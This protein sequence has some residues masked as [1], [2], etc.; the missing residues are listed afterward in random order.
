MIDWMERGERFTFPP[1]IV[2]RS[3]EFVWSALFLL[4]IYFLLLIRCS[5]ERASERAPAITAVCSSSQK[6]SEIIKIE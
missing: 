5:L 3:T 2:V 4:T 6:E 1:F